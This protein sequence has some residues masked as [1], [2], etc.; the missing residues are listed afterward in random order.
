LLISA[1]VLSGKVLDTLGFPRQVQSLHLFIG[2]LICGLQIFIAI[3][4]YSR[5]TPAAQAAT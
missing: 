1:Q 4:L 5:V 2:S 3:I